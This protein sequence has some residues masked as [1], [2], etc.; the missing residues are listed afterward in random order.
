[1]QV[2]CISLYIINQVGINGI[3]LEEK[4]TWIINL[5][6]HTECKLVLG[7]VYMQGMRLISINILCIFSLVELHSV[8]LFSTAVSLTHTKFTMYFCFGDSV[9]CI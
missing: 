8:G 9:R 7:Q 3:K 4:Q 5:L 2:L 1:M 6:V